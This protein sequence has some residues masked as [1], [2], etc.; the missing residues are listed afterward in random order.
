MRIRSGPNLADRG[1]AR[2]LRGPGGAT[3]EL[4]RDGDP[5]VALH[6]S[7]GGSSKRVISDAVTADP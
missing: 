7:T 2:G 6:L 4:V 1:T 3:G 5:P